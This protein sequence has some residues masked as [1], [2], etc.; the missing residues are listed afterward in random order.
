MPTEAILDGGSMT[1]K[2]QLCSLTHRT[3]LPQQ[4]IEIP[5]QAADNELV[6]IKLW[7]KNIN[8]SWPNP[9]MQNVRGGKVILKNDSNVQI[10]FGKEVK[11]CKI[12]CTV[13]PE[14]TPKATTST[15][16]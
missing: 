10:N 2:S 7:E 14:A 15:N 3:I 8:I 16:Q 6:S 12:R 9:Q 13:T 1:K 5:V 4:V 11:L